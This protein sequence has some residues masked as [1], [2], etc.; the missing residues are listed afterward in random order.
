MF[1]CTNKQKEFIERLSL[2]ECYIDSYFYLSDK[3][4]LKELREIKTSRLDKYVSVKNI[5]R[6]LEEIAEGQITIKYSEE[7]AL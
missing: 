6:A 5:G 1:R 4:S 7:E 3:K 2:E